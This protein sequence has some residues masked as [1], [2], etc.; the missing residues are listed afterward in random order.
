[1]KPSRPL[2]QQRPRQTPETRGASG[3]GSFARGVSLPLPLGPRPPPHVTAGGLRR[4][5]VRS[6]APRLRGAAAGRRAG[7]GLASGG[8]RRPSLRRAFGAARFPPSGLRGAG[9]PYW[10]CCA[11]CLTVVLGKRGG[12]REEPLSLRWSQGLRDPRWFKCRSGL[13]K[14]LCSLLRLLVAT[15]VPAAWEP[16]RTRC[17][18]PARRTRAGPAAALAGVGLLSGLLR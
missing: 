10:L 6:A 11:W 4:L 7:H 5:R 18:G 1:M 9:Q 8:G 2:H 12:C 17:A 13:L 16:S 3:A 15:P 14:A